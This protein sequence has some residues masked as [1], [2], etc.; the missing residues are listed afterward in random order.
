MI[1]AWKRRRTRITNTPF[2]F[3]PKRIMRLRLPTKLL[4][5]DLLTVLHPRTPDTDNNQMNTVKLKK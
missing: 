1:Q 2:T 5:V 3:T 4:R